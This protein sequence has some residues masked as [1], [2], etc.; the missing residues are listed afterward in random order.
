[1]E[2]FHVPTFCKLKV[3]HRTI[4]ANKVPLFLSVTCP[5]LNIMNFCIFH[6][7]AI[8]SQYNLHTQQVY[9]RETC[10]RKCAG[11][12]V[13]GSLL[14]AAKLSQ[15]WD[16]TLLRVLLPRSIGHSCSISISLLMGISCSWPH[17]KTQLS[18]CQQ[19]PGSFWPINRGRIMGKS[20]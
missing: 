11:P 2:G 1:M 12:P 14:P 6:L 10:S 7:N 8:S 19:G 9:G 20:K 15:M 3:L 5:S 13:W 4:D 18:D 16:F 17:I